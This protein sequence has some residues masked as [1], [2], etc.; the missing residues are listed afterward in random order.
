M[1]TLADMR[2]L[3]DERIE[4]LQRELASARAEIEALRVQV[5]CWKA[6]ADESSNLAQSALHDNAVMSRGL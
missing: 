4:K 1:P 3:I 5:A 2:T 6:Q